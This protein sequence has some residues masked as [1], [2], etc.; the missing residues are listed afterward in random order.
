MLS[1]A[2]GRDWQSMTASVDIAGWSAAR[3]LEIVHDAPR[4]GVSAQFLDRATCAWMI[5]RAA[6]LQES[7]LVYDPVSGRAVADDVRTNSCATFALQNLD[8]VTL[9]IRERIANTMSVPSAHLE[10]TSVFRYQAGQ[11]FG[12]HVDYLTPSP[13]LNAEIRQWGQRPLTFLVYLND[14]FDAGETHFLKIDRKLRGG[15]GDALLFRNIGEDG[16]PD[17]MT[18]HEGAPPTR[19]VKWLLSQFIRDKPQPLG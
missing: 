14:D 17:E 13:Q 2:S 11:Q 1:G 18:W 6:P 3:A 4:I 16:A 10:R 8:L 5:E 12:A 19:G 15:V 7:A 9:L